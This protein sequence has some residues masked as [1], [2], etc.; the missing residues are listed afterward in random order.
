MAQAA[1]A[2]DLNPGS[3]VSD[4][5]A[6]ESLCA[7]GMAAEATGPRP[8]GVAELQE[9]NNSDGIFWAVVDG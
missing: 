4:D 5:H 3:V 8:I 6:D 2:L 9:H 7:D 1:A